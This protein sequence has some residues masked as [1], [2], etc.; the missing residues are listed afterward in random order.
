[1]SFNKCYVNEISGVLPI[2]LVHDMDMRVDKT[3]LLQVQM[4]S[5]ELNGAN[6]NDS[7]ILHVVAHFL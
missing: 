1:M 5:S 3:V 6:R 4:N 2:D 7:N